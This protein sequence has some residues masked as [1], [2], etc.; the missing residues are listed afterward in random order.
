[1]GLGL[2]LRTIAAIL[3]ALAVASTSALAE[4][5]RAGEADTHPYYAYYV[6]FRVAENGVYGHTYI[7]YGHRNAAGW[8]TSA[9][10]ADIH[11]IGDFASM[12]LGHFM[13]MEA[14][15]RPDR[16]TLGRRISSRFQ[17]A[18][19]ADEYHRLTAAIARTRAKGHAWSI[20]AYNCNDFVADVA[21]GI[22]MQV[23][24]T[25]TLPYD[26]V[27]MLRAMNEQAQRQALATAAPIARP[28]RTALVR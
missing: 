25:L 24:S 2:S 1:M 6:E 28:R 17:R 10:Y 22:G 20:V 12:V 18:L 5:M 7:A 11:P 27:P 26:F 19:T 8:P 14:A 9:A 4:P 16:D 3:A 13:P 23:P 15:T 21:R